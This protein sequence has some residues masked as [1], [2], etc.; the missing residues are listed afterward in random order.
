MIG[1]TL[2]KYRIEAQVSSGG[3]GTV[4]RATHAET[5]Q[6][7]AVKVLQQAF[8][9][10]RSFLQR[11]NREVLALQKVQHPNVV[12]IFDVGSEG[13]LHFYAME[14]LPQSLT[15]RLRSG[16]IGLPQA[17][18]VASQVARG[19]A[20]VHAAG[21]RHRDVK[22]SNILFDPEGGAKVAD[23]GIAK[24]SDAT[25][26]TQTGVIVGT[27]AYMAPE[28]VDDV[29]AGPRADV[30]ALGI[31]LYEMIVGRPPFDGPT[32]LD[33]LRKHRY[34]LPE[35]PK[36]FK[37]D[38]PAALAHL[39]MGMLAKHPSKRPDT[40]AMV[41]D[42]LDHIAENI[43]AEPTRPSLGS[44]GRELS[45]AE[46][47]ERYERAAAGV[48]RWTRRATALV[49]AALL[50]YLAYKAVAYWLLTPADYWREAEALEAGDKARA[51]SR[52]D[53]LVRRFPDAPE[54]AKARARLDAIREEERQQQAKIAPR[55]GGDAAIRAQIA[56]LHYRRG[57]KQA[58]AGELEHAR[59]IYRMVR[60]VF[61]DTP[62]GARADSRLQDLDL[63]LPRPPEPPPPKENAPA[64]P[65]EKQPPAPPGPEATGPLK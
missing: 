34:T 18:R 39:I 37:P 16:P 48:A 45:P 58:E 24:L 5:G 2:G 32:T 4:Y 38:I 20:A 53:A 1:T 65:K 54:A 60:E 50:A 3:M 44:R 41:A 31:V 17:L 46:A 42:A 23:F 63:R 25:R 29:S 35:S 33:I 6:V 13:D 27:P 49:A 59:R 8:A 64:E 51:A 62:W 36:S 61:S 30:Y 28:Q 14:Y 22:P 52:Y 15:D 55:G 10:D 21:V 56:Y 12:R 26:V 43:A 9:T 7:A 11:F 47:V 57:E 19:L 40:M